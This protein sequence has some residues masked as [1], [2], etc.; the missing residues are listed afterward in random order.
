MAGFPDPPLPANNKATGFL[1]YTGFDSLE[2]HKASIQC[3]AIIGPPAKRHIKT[4]A[5][6]SHAHFSNVI[7]RL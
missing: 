4:Y 3:W 6:Y 2:N 5:A 7:M 1:S